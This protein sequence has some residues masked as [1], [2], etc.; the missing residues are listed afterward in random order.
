[1]GNRYYI[2]KE[3]QKTKH[4]KIVDKIVSRTQ[5]EYVQACNYVLALD[6]SRKKG[7]WGI[8]DFSWCV[9]R[10]HDYFTN[11]TLSFDERWGRGEKGGFIL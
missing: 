10:I 7:G 3:N 4:K 11:M 8:C 9:L 2:N 1:M 6:V 5:I